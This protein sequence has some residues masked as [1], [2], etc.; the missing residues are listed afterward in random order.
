MEEYN[1]ENQNKQKAKQRAKP[2]VNKIEKRTLKEKKLI[3]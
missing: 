2:K 3:I 1:L